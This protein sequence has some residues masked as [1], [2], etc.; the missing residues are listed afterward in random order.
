MAGICWPKQL[1]L[2]PLDAPLT[3]V[4]AFVRVLESLSRFSLVVV[5]TPP[6]TLCLESAAELAAAARCALR[7][8]PLWQGEEVELSEK[9]LE[10]FLQQHKAQ[11]VSR[12]PG[13]G[14][15]E[16]AVYSSEAATRMVLVTRATFQQALLLA[17]GNAGPSPM[18]FAQIDTEKGSL[19]FAASSI[20]E[21]ET[22][23]PVR[24]ILDE[25]PLVKSTMELDT[26]Q[27]SCT[28]VLSLAESRVFSSCDG[29]FTPPRKNPVEVELTEKL[30]E[31]LASALCRPLAEFRQALVATEAVHA[32]SQAESKLATLESRFAGIWQLLH[33]KVEDVK[34]L[35]DTQSQAI[36]RLSAMYQ[37]ISQ[38]QERIHHTLEATAH[39]LIST[40]EELKQ[41]LEARIDAGKQL[42]STFASI[43]VRRMR[44][45]SAMV[46]QAVQQVEDGSV[47]M[48]VYSHKH[49]TMWVRLEVSGNG[50]CK[51]DYKAVQCGSQKLIISS[52]DE[53]AAGDYTITLFNKEGPKVMSAPVQFHVE[54]RMQ[55]AYFA[56]ADYATSFLYSSVANIAEV[57]SGFYDPAAVNILRKVAVCWLDQEEGMVET[58][59]ETVMN[60]VAQGERAVFEALMA[61]GC[62]MSS[63]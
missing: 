28:P 3:A 21:V 14:R 11:Y 40:S 39:S 33:S 16:Q 47:E 42:S 58:V 4:S 54:A 61:A 57:E 41:E 60:T 17:T 22:Y 56:G 31:E 25:T 19:V 1:F 9:E 15:V 35:K 26:S 44:K 52:P 53:L 38:T 13:S 49:Y 32:L 36:Q 20:F 62:R 59:L 5:E 46:I 43:Q 24:F 7:V 34:G 27:S 51:R 50:S 2:L 48:Q 63:S 18:L 37:D 45:S 55:P 12:G 29:F 8:E 23:E 30:N 6:T 10:S